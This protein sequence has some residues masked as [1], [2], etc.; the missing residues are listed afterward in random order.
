MQQKILIEFINTLDDLLSR[1]LQEGEGLSQLTF[2]QFQYLEAIHSLGVTT[3]TEL[4]AL[5]KI[6]KA[7]VT[8]GINTLVR[9]GFV[10]KTQSD[11]DRRVFHI[12]L[13]EAAQRLAQARDNALEEYGALVSRALSEEEARQFEALLKKLVSYFK[14]KNSKSG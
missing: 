10:T 11:L 6:T 2:S 7:S 4:A 3:T 1:T 12:H 14:N 13:T 5:L 9:L 8:A